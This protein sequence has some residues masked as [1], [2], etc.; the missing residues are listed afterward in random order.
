MCPTEVTVSKSP[1][2]TL[3]NELFL[4]VASHVKSFKDLN[5]LVRTSRVF[6]GLFNT[7][8]YR[9][10]VAASY[11]IRVR[12]VRRVLSEYRLA[13]L[14]LLLDNGL[15]VN[16]T[17]QYYSYFYPDEPNVTMLRFVCERLDQERSVPLVRLLLQRGA[18]TNADDGRQSY[19]VLFRA[20]KY[21]YSELAA[22]LLAH[23]AD[24]NAVVYG[25]DT[26]LHCANRKNNASMVNLLVTHGAAID[27]RNGDG[28]TPLVLAIRCGNRDIIPVL[29]AHGAGV[30]AIDNHGWTP[31][32]WASFV[33]SNLFMVELLLENGADVNAI[34][35]DGRSP[36]HHALSQNKQSVA[37]LLLTHG[38]D[39][40]VLNRRDREQLGVF[41]RRNN[42]KKS[43]GIIDVNSYSFLQISELEHE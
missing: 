33:S 8:L 4:D 14:T 17:A 16:H 31:L 5:S 2:M 26:P 3:P 35:K 19:T 23:G 36:L 42:G 1:L 24:P 43:T 34:S 40:R 10:A 6:H 21:G 41:N 22:L 20:V 18:D 12:I 25:G 30:N 7:Q 37:A 39:V 32:H 15:S 11:H 13:A 29:L 28:D 38:A 27:G 9:R